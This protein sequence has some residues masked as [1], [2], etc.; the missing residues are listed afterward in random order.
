MNGDVRVVDDVPAA[1]A[2]V[3]S[4]SF[5][6][7]PDP[8]SFA[9]ALSGGSTARP[10][11]EQLAKSDIDWSVTTV[12]WG[13][14]RLVPLDHPDSNYLLA[15]E[16]FLD[17]AGSFRAIHPMATSG[18][19]AAYAAVLRGLPAVDVVHLGMGE[20]GHTASLF[21]GSPALEAPPGELVV[22][23]G[24]E[25]HAH[26]RMTFTFGAIARARLALF[27]VMGAGKRAMFSR[28]QEGEA[29]PAGRVAAHRVL[30]LADHAAVSR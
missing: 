24:D 18:G 21:P 30:W 26:P 22:E 16:A 11:Y 2:E 12:L 4:E 10:C 17:R 28:I 25:F 20:D 14:E 23:T 15:K 27:T 8:D 6:A 7:R 29:L 5:A 19:A 3:V 13:D 9:I 1:F